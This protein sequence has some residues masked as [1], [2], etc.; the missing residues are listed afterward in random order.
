MCLAEWLTRALNCAECSQGSHRLKLLPVRMFRF[1]RFDTDNML[2]VM[3]NQLMQHYKF[4]VLCIFMFT[5]AEY[6]FYQGKFATIFILS[7]RIY[8]LR[9]EKIW[10]CFNN[11][12]LTIRVT[13]EGNLICGILG[14]SN[15]VMPNGLAANHADDEDLSHPHVE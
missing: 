5:R 6:S 2:F 15:G 11:D 4:I 12:F 1:D 13:F 3:K 9:T 14:D 10:L 7:F 8:D